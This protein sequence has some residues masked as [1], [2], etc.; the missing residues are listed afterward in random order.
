MTNISFYFSKL[1]LVFALG[2]I[3]TS[4]FSQGDYSSP[5]I[6]QRADPMIYRHTDGWFYFIAT[7]PEFDRI[8]LRRSKT[9]AGLAETKPAVIWRKHDTGPQ[10]ANIWAPEIHYIEGRWVIYYAAGD[11]QKP[12]LI[13]MFALSNGHANPIAGE[14]LDEGQIKTPWDSFALDATTFTH[15]GKRYLL[16]AEADGY[17]PTQTYNSAL[18]LAELETPTKIKLPITVLSEPA[19]PWE[20]IGY[21][22]NEGPS[23]IQRNGKLFV[24]YSASATDHHYAMGLLW[25]DENSDIMNAKTWYKS[26]EPV[27]FTH[28]K[29]KR[30]GP[31]HNSFAVAEDG[32]TDLMVYHARPYKEIKGSPLADP[33]R[34]THVRVLG[35]D[36]SGMP[37]FRQNEA[38]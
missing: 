13:R 7:A 35:W 4:V 10:A 37:D 21:K 9:I 29:L 16:W 12:W 1:A 23:V 6:K 27:F 28:E 20:T 14:W 38:D 31:G 11:G 30:F 36:K 26:P 3:S 2:L 5:L 33:N 19:L 34:H 22:V 8:E 17:K 25:A 24:T 32:V 18:L 15:K